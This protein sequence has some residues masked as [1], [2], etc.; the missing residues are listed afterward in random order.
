[1]LISG[2]LGICTAYANSFAGL[3]T[4]RLLLNLAGGPL[5]P[6][7]ISYLSQFYARGDLSKRLGI[8]CSALPIAG[9]VAGVLSWGVFSIQSSSLK[10]WQVL[11]V[12]APAP[13]WD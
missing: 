11:F 3:L 9:C 7:I 6:L 5:M 10:G 4:I 8:W 2:I 1:M 13:V 12:S